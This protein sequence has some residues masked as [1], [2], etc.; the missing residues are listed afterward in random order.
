MDLLN[1][2]LLGYLLESKEQ[3]ANSP[4][5]LTYTFPFLFF[6][7]LFFLLFKQKHLL[8]LQKR[9][10]ILGRKS[11]NSINSSI[12]YYFCTSSIDYKLH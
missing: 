11:N 10:N 3:L 7:F 6:F 9:A 5:L 12:D 8:Q 2:I 1:P 4:L